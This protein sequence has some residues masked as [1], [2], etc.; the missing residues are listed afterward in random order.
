MKIVQD[1]LGPLPPPKKKCGLH[2]EDYN[3]KVVLP[4]MFSSI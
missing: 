4:V 3:K 1:S 2:M